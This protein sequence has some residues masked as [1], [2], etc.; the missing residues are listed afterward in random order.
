MRS[1]NFIALACYTLLVAYVSLAPSG[2]PGL[3]LWYKSMH[4]TVYA[5]FALLASA[6]ASNGRGFGYL[7]L[8]IGSYSALLEL[9][10]QFSGGRY[11]SG[12]DLLANCLGLALGAAL[13]LGLTPALRRASH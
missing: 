9:L 10:Q 5:I 8:L 11:L 2:G 1:L 7:L 4:F 13:A 3:P 6:C 12:A